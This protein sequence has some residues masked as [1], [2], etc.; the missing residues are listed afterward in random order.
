MESIKQEKVHVEDMESASIP[1]LERTPID[2]RK[3]RRLVLKQDL[4]IIPL[5]WIMFFVAYLVGASFNLFA[6]QSSNNDPRIA[7]LLA[8]RVSWVYKRAWT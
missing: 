5:L 4:I 3:E 8:T 7:E 1:V 2:A 6:E